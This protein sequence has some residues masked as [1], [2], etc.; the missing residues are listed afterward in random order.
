M[1]K[2][3]IVIKRYTTFKIGGTVKYFA[4]I[5]NKE[6]LINT[7]K[8]SKDKNLPI[9]VLGGGSNVLADDKSYNG[10]VLKMDNKEVEVEGERIIAGAGVPLKKVVEISLNNSLT[11]FEWGAGIPGSVGGATYGNASAFGESVE[12]SLQ[13]VEIFNISSEKFSHITKKECNYG[14]KESIFKNDKNIIIFKVI[15]KLKKG[16]KKEIKRKM[17]ELISKRKKAHP[18][19]LP[20]AG[21]IFKNYQGK[22]SDKK[23]IERFPLL[24][25]FNKSS[26]IPV[27]YLIDKSGLKGRRVGGA[28]VSSKHANFIVN[29]KG[30]K[31]KDVLNLIDVIKKEVK[32]KFNIEIEEEVQEF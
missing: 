16:N 25:K 12:D 2:K 21:C 31:K 29:D 28:K 22:V 10:I 14:N 7:I 9:F 11:G 15:F 32:K 24:E 23:I 8:F 5:K 30:A 18:N 20:S 17:E 27:S 3:D 26:I 6:D 19:S 1:I 13:K 4:T